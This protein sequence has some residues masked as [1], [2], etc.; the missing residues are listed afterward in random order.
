MKYRRMQRARRV[1]AALRTAW[2]A[3]A[4]AAACAAAQEDGLYADFAT[5]MGGFTCRLEYAKAPLAVANFVGLAEGSKAWVDYAVATVRTNT[6]FYNGITFHRVIT[7]FMIQAGSPNG[8]GTDGP[9][10]QFPDEFD[11]SLRHDGPG[12]L[13]MANSGENSNGSQ[14]FVTVTATPQLNDVHTIFGR[15][16][17]GQAVVDAID[18]VACDTNDRPLEAVTIQSIAIRRVG[19]AALAFNAATQG[20]PYA[21]PLRLGLH[22]E[23]NSLA[24]EFPREQ[25]GNCQIFTGTDLVSWTS[26]N[27]GYEIAPPATSGLVVTLNTEGD[28][29]QFYSAARVKY[30]SSAFVP[31][32]MAGRTMQLFFDFGNGTNTMHFAADGLTGTYTWPPFF[33]PGTI[34]GYSWQI[35][36]NALYVYNGYLWP[37]QF[38]TANPMLL[39]FV[40]GLNND[41][42]GTFNGTYVTNVNPISGIPVSG[43][44]TL[45][46]AP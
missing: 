20:L 41:R 26:M 15:V 3:L 9:G 16:V 17:D 40:F 31:W 2:L 7:N 8:L 36:Q 1:P 24:L 30:P 32:S 29:R 22:V 5:S 18:A 19:A 44:F 35:E 14:F 21:T 4:A 37:V 43:T 6:P 10:Y 25:H 28:P 46:P 45:T 11:A 23:T 34:V 12:V 39:E 27:L 38:T 13:S 33:A 42:A